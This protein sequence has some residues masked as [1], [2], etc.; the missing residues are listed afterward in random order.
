MVKF[1]RKIE[2]ALLQF[3][4]FGE[5]VQFSIDGQ[6]THRSILGSIVSLG[7]F[8]TVLAFGAKKFSISLNY[9]DT[10]FFQTM[11]KDYYDKDVE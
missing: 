11:E 2:A 3:D 1:A 8:A 5:S 10:L 6:S 9:Q 4:R 7:I